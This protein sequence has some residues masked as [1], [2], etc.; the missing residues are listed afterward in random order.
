MNL[1]WS[2]S[3]FKYELINISPAQFNIAFLKSPKK[4]MKDCYFFFTK[5]NYFAS[6]FIPTKKTPI[7]Q[8]WIGVFFSSL[9]KLILFQFSIDWKCR[10]ISAREP[11]LRFA[12]NKALGEEFSSLIKAQDFFPLL[13][14]C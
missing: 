14:S 2:N 6:C 4:I 10:T 1:S 3:P 5:K 12:S 9:F 11:I 7:N 13:R 8:Y